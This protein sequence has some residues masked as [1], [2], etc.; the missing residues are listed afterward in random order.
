VIDDGAIGRFMRPNLTFANGPFDE[1]AR[2]PAHS[3][4]Q[5]EGVLAAQEISAVKS[6]KAQESDLPLAVTEVPDRGDALVVG[7]KERT[8]TVSLSLL[9][10]LEPPS[11]VSVLPNCSCWRSSSCERSRKEPSHSFET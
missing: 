11:E 10:V 4:A 9:F 7:H 8:T 6:N 1:T 5:K 2:I 3:W